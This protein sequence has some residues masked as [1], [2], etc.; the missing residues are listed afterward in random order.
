MNTSP[1]CYGLPVRTQLE[2]LSV[3]KLGIRKVVKS[4]IIRKDAEKIVAMASKIKSVTPGV[5]VTLICTRNI[6]SKSLKLL[7]EKGI[8]VM[9]TNETLL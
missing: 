2:A 1:S 4:R 5:E 8:E 9:F 7:A 3:N 6:C